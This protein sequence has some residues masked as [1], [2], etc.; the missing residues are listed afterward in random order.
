MGK[1]FA[2]NHFMKPNKWFWKY[3]HKMSGRNIQIVIETEK[4]LRLTGDLKN[5][6]IKT[7]SFI[8]ECGKNIIIRPF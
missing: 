1:Q 8:I 2:F 6:E 5:F 3:T 4:V 7:K